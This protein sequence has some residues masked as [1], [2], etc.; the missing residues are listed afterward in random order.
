KFAR[1]TVANQRIV[2]NLICRSAV[3]DGVIRYNPCA[4]VKVPKGLKTTP[5]QLPSDEELQIVKDVKNDPDG[6]L[7]YFI[8]YTG[9]RRGEALALTHKD[10][11]RKKKII[12]VNKSVTYIGQ[13]PSIKEPKTAAGVREIILLDKLAEVLPR[14]IGLIFPGKNGELMHQSE[15]ERKWEH[16]QKRVGVTLTAHQLRHGYATMLYEAGIPERDAM[17]LLGHTDIT[18]T[19]K[20]YTHIRKSRKESTAALL[21]EAAKNF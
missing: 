21:N 3:L 2:V 18:M 12:T 15:Y 8:L 16:W 13:Q 10:I 6:L 9:C 5:R 1:K 19:H 17:E 20:V 7:P 4:E 11:D 14:G